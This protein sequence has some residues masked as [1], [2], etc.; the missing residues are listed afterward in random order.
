MET[1]NVILSYWWILP[2]LFGL[3]I[4]TKFFV[5]V[6]ADELATIE[7]RYFGREMKDG[8]TVALSGEV[9]IQAKILGAGLHFLIPFLQVAKKYK[10]LIIQPDEQGLVTAITGAPIPQGQW[11]A[12]HVECSIFQDGE[13][14]LKNGGQ[15]GPQIMII[16]PGE[17]RINPH[18]FDVDIVKAPFVQQNQI[19]TVEAIAGQPIE[20][21]EMNHNSIQSSTNK[22]FF[23]DIFFCLVFFIGKP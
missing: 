10:Y 15:K 23:I 9:G 22:N 16:P 3:F 5:N 18:L 12:N 19:A 1:F 4:F 6:A 20:P 8:R 13:A 11:M 17:H 21:G 2:S 7:W 14:F